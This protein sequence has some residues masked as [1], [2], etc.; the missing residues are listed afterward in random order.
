M[1]KP[2]FAALDALITEVPAV[3]DIVGHGSDSF[4][5]WWIEFRLDQHHEAAWNVIQEISHILNYASY[6][7]QLKTTFKPVSPPPY[8]SGGPEQSLSWIIESHAEE[9]S[10]DIC[11]TWLRNRLP[12]PISDSSAWM[13]Q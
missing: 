8:K 13:Q 11:A 1:D 6:D 12:E 9:V 10:P 4:R 5:C 3:T 2:E 7:E